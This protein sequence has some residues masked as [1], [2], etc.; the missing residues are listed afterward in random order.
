MV[1]IAIG[2]LAVFGLAG[3]LLYMRRRQKATG[4]ILRNSEVPSQAGQSSYVPPTPGISEAKYPNMQKADF[5][6]RD[7]DDLGENGV[8]NVQGAYGQL[9]TKPESGVN[10]PIDE[11]AIVTDPV[12][13]V[14]DLFVSRGQVSQGMIPTARAINSPG[15][16]SP[17]YTEMHGIENGHRLRFVFRQ[18]LISSKRQI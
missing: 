3:L 9:G 4:E 17:M 8:S 12:M 11:R 1:G 2:I 16:P 18:F 5:V 7:I 10:P 6:A 14:R 13:S 15:S